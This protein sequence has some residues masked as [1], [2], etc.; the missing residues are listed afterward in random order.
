MNVV[1]Y[2]DESKELLNIAFCNDYCRE[3][4]V[5]GTTRDCTEAAEAVAVQS[6]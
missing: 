2:T 6:S 3:L 4:E 5:T 1:M